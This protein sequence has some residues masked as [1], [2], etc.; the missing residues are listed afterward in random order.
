MA[1]NRI[2]SDSKGKNIAESYNKFK[3]F[4]GKIYTGMKV[5]RSHHW[6]YDSG[7]WKE[8]K[9]TPDKWEIHY[10]VTK[11]RKGKAPE[12]SGVPVGTKYHWYILAHQVVEKL[13]ANDY[14]TELAGM[15][16][17]LA[18]QRANKDDWNISD[19]AQ[20]K[21]MIKILRELADHLENELEGGKTKVKPQ[22]EKIA[23][24]QDK[25]VRKKPTIKPFPK[26]MV[27]KNEPFHEDKPTK[28]KHK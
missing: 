12:G 11:R 21:R 2:E 18:H 5:G 14:S 8:T 3:E 22:K 23:A 13:N 25:P 10:S 6:I 17:K 7:E 16:F 28:G 24:T 26:R 27:A 9:I 19:N 4:E 1:K 20:K 15:K